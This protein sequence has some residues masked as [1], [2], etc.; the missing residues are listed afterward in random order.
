MARYSPVVMS[1]KQERQQGRGLNTMWYTSSTSGRDLY[2]LKA[3]KPE[4]FARRDGGGAGHSEAVPPGFDE[5]E[6]KPGWFYNRADKIFFESA[7]RKLFWFDEDAGEHKELYEGRE[8][9]F[10][11]TGG[12]ASSSAASPEATT[13]SSSKAPKTVVIPDLH[14]V[15]AA[16]KADF[17]HI[18]KPS[19]MLG[20]FGQEVAARGFHEKLVR[21]LSL[22]RSSWS[23]DAL[24]D[25]MKAALEDVTGGPAAS[26]P[27][28]ALVMLTGRRA[29]A[30]A[31]P[32]ACFH[33]AKLPAKTS[34]AENL[35]P[36]WSA[37]SSSCSAPAPP[38]PIVVA[39]PCAAGRVVPPRHRP[40]TATAQA[41]PTLATTHV[42]VEEDEA[43]FSAVA[44]GG[45]QLA[46]GDFKE[47]LAPQLLK[48]WM[49]TGCLALLR[50]A[51][52]K[53]LQIPSAIACARFTPIRAALS[54]QN[55]APA[56]KRQKLAGSASP[57][58]SAGAT[59][60]SSGGSQ[61]QVRLRQILLRVM[62]PGPPVMDPVRRKQVT[63]S[64]EEA[65]TQMLEVLQ[66]LEADG[67]AS[68]QKVCREVSE[69]QSALKGGELVGDMGWLDR[70]K[71]VGIQQDK[72]KVGV[73]PQVPAAV[74]KAAFE[75]AV[76]EVHDLV[77][78]EIGV[79]LLQRTA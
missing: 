71:G 45:L 37:S 36:A 38:R 44:A 60:A 18:D 17:A 75:L 62:A 41:A 9:P 22:S 78:T 5:M 79:H 31:S 25:A 4:L 53:G 1:S 7:S 52:K 6:E 54:T 48:G 72:A 63:R 15:A 21:R 10:M 12:A 70:V 11:F 16:L 42:A 29:S 65:E 68:F 74:L 40:S 26:A 19:A 39:V 46:D 33:L 27:P 61:D 32:G 43:L 3:K 69:C 49:R 13:A 23:D 67:L 66:N 34:P 56:P 77:T 8:F 28:T 50:S 55:E 64:Q 20:V 35:S 51:R 59:G 47:L 76:G 24:A 14:R 58:F 57:I 30:L 73:R 2:K